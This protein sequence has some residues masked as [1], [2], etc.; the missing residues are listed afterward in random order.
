MKK[1][2]VLAAALFTMVLGA[3]SDSEF[4]GFKRAETGLHYR[5]FN[6]DENGKTVQNGDGILVRYVIMNHRNDSVIVDSK[7]VSRDGSGYTGF[8]MSGSTFKGSLEDGMMMMAKGDS[9]EFLI[10][11]EL[12]FL[13]NNK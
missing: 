7:T 1:T 8:G 2:Q 6:H 4:D 13:K 11:A 10:T 5:F 3:C 9:A 12:F